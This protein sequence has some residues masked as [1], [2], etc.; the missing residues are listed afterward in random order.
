MLRAVHMS[1]AVVRGDGKES[2]M[3]RRRRWTGRGNLESVS[4]S[5]AAMSR[6]SGTRRAGDRRS[7]AGDSEGQIA[8]GDGRGGEGR[9][10]R[11]H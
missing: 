3:K 8:A 4:G 1:S 9:G 7:K 6:M 11:F 5:E 2:E 10:R